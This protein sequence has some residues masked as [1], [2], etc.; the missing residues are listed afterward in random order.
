MRV[1]HRTC[2]KRQP[3]HGL[4]R[5]VRTHRSS[6][7]NRDEEF[8]LA[9]V[10]FVW[11]DVHSQSLRLREI[12]WWDCQPPVLFP[13]LNYMSPPQAIGLLY[14]IKSSH[15]TVT[16]GYRDTCSCYLPNSVIVGLKPASVLRDLSNS[17]VHYQRKGSCP[18]QKAPMSSKASRIRIPIR[19]GPSQTSRKDVV[20]RPPTPQSTKGKS[21]THKSLLHAK[22]A[23]DRTI[24]NLRAIV[25]P[26]A[27]RAK[28]WS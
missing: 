22:L 9:V 20:V 14:R 10:S 24:T 12:D 23:H 2:E 25:Q 27:E 6:D 19:L 21:N 28:G 18:I 8:L 5:R 3:R 1:G 7:V 16:K 13:G 26:R 4:G 15:S 11:K 17:I